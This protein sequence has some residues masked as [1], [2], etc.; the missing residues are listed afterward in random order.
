MMRMH[1]CAWPST[2]GQT[3]ASS[4]RR[5]PTLTRLHT[6][7]ATCL[8]SKT[9]RAHSLLAGEQGAGGCPSSLHSKGCCVPQPAYLPP[10]MG[11]GHP[12]PGNCL[13]TF[14]AELHGAKSIPSSLETQEQQR[15][16]ASCCCRALP[17]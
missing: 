17:F 1:L 15:C 5:T 14:S 12:A 11:P 8:A 13:A 6:V 16:T 2:Q 3:E 4:S 10:C 9:P 7:Q